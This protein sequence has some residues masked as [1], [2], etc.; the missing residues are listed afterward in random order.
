M[1]VL[2]ISEATPK[3]RAVNDYNALSLLDFC[4]GLAI[5]LVVLFHYSKTWFGWQGVH[6]FIVLS[7][8]GLTYSCLKKNETISWKHWYIRR[9]E[10]ILPVYWLLSLFGFFFRFVLLYV[11][12]LM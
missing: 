6:L 5:I 11:K 1:K 9:A 8:F 3:N 4:K 10:R 12:R 7:G 2:G